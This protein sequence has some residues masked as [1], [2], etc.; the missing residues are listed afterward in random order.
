VVAEA[1]EINLSDW[2]D[3]MKWWEVEFSSWLFFVV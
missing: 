1:M 2:L 3:H